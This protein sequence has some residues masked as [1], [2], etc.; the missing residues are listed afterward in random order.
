MMSSRLRAAIAAAFLFAMPI[1]EAVAYD[2]FARAEHPVL[3]SR[4]ESEAR[5]RGVPPRIA[6]S[7]ATTSAPRRG[8][9]GPMNVV[10]SVARHYGFAGRDIRDPARNIETGVR[11]LDHLYHRFGTWDRAV[12]AY[13]WGPPA[14]ARGLA[15]A[16]REQRIYVSLVLDRQPVRR[17]WT[18]GARQSPAPSLQFRSQDDRGLD[19]GQGYERAFPGDTGWSPGYS[20]DYRSREGG[21]RDD[22]QIQ[23]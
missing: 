12:L 10:P 8:A 6:L 2:G 18:R 15:G 4:I 1:G 20:E 19:F 5:R 23:S 21:N 14:G 7:I 11:L 22:G 13:Q 9:T 17:D 3:A 16:S